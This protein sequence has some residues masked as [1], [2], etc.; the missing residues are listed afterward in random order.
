MSAPNE[1]DLPYNQAVRMAGLIHKMREKQPL[2]EEEQQQ[3]EAW[4]NSSESHAALFKSLQDR[5]KVAAELEALIQYD[6]ENAVTA[7]FKAIGAQPPSAIK[8]W[9]GMIW[10]FSV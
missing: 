9:R 2:T 4:L 5:A 7:V 8:K 6:E 3:L 1:N 10:R